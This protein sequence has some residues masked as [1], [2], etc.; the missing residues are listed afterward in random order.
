MK[1][2]LRCVLAC[3]LLLVPALA[4]AQQVA[5][6]LVKNNIDLPGGP[7]GNPVSSITT[8]AVNQV[9][10]YCFGVTTTGD[11]G[12][13]SRFWGNAVGGPGALIRSETTIGDFEQTAFESFFGFSNEGEVSYSPTCNNLDSGS[14]GLDAVWYGDQPIAVEEEVYPHLEGWYWRFAS[15][16]GTTAHGIPY[17]VGGITNVQ[18]GSTQNRGL[19]YGWDGAPVLVGGDTVDG[20]AEPLNTGTA[21]TFDF[22]YSAYGAYYLCQVYTTGPTATNRHVVMNGAVVTID[23]M[24]MSRG[25]A[26]PAAAGGL[27]G[28]NW[29]NFDYMGVTESGYYMVTGDN[30]GATAT[31]EFVL[32]NGAIVL[33]EGDLVG[34]YPLVGA[35]ERAYM[36]E[37]GDWAAVWAVDV[38]GVSR[39]VLLL[40]GEIMVMEGDEVDFTGDGLPD[41]DHVLTDFTGIAA[42]A[43]G[44]RGPDGRVAVYFV[45]DLVVPDMVVARPLADETND[46][47][48]AG[49][50]E[51]EELP[52]R[53]MVRAGMVVFS[54][55]VVPVMLSR[56]E[57]LPAA[58]GALVRWTAAGLASGSF[59][60][61]ARSGAQSRVVPYEADGQGGYRAHDLLA[62]G[63]VTYALYLR[64]GSHHVLLEARTVE[65]APPAAGLQIVGIY[66]NPFN[67]QTSVAFAV[68]RSQPVKVAVH[69]LDGR[70][71]AVLADQIFVGGRHQV[72]WNG[73]DQAGQPVPSGT[74][75]ARVVAQDGVQ[76]AK[77]MLVK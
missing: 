15:R 25:S 58:D 75:L 73:L 53:A 4:G 69:A 51:P 7:A 45:A 12:V 57:A 3:A 72:A 20:I 62:S 34:G 13:I 48:A 42:L 63:T 5:T 11:E 77:L 10:G 30:S 40:N 52:S 22:R 9:G 2:L 38:E 60:L 17:F 50:T 71:V 61:V 19:F 29:E 47:E 24:P 23:G 33:R 8:P 70:Q 37:D 41:P 27:P 64:D 76:T 65:L 35:I 55:Q 18:G 14:T 31:D 1:T 36:N 6:A 28:E 54:E 67:P 21:V 26:V 32:I 74:Y 39:E 56:F 59:E 49:R 66:P 43:V 46:L 44:D 68:G 16:P